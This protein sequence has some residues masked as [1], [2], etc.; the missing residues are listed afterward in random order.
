[1]SSKRIIGLAWLG[2]LLA[3]PL[4]AQEVLELE[5]ISIIGNPE[6]PKTLVGKVDF[7]VLENEELEKLEAAGA[8][9]GR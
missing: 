3:Q 9:T 2:L 5:A 1:M 7:K 4:S 6:L 8:Y